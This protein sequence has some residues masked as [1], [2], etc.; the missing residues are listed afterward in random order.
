VQ[1][2]WENLQYFER[3]GIPSASLIGYGQSG[4]GRGFRGALITTE[5]ADTQ[6]LAELARCGDMRLIQPEWVAGVSRQLAAI[7]RTLHSHRFAHNDLKWRNLLV[8][9]GGELF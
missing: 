6:D 9:G 3:L 2:E 1:A 8:N 5:L 7:T 4:W